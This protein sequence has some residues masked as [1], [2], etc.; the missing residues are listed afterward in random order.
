MTEVNAT[1]STVVS[2]GNK[3]KI[4]VVLQA[5]CISDLAGMYDLVS[6]RISPGAIY[7]L[8]GEE[9]SEVGTGQ[10]LTSS[11]GPFN[12]RGLIAASVQLA[13]PTAGF[14]FN[15]VCGRIALP[16]PS[17]LLGGGYSNI[18]TQSPAQ[19]A[20]S[21]VNSVTGVLTIYYSV[22]FTS[23]TLERQYFGVYTPL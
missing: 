22:W 17:Q 13:T 16:Q 23:N 3:G 20:Q 1:G 12:I 10:Y 11:T 4:N 8:P 19:A 21:V 2:S 15:E 9:I 14:I 18:V 7:N 5:T 6:T